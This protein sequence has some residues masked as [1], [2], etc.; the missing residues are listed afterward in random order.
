MCDWGLSWVTLQR[1]V[2]GA[3]IKLQRFK[4]QEAECG[5]VGGSQEEGGDDEQSRIK[6]KAGK[7]PW[8]EN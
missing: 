3:G 8:K 6:G 7:V 5:A 4:R 2:S 1:A